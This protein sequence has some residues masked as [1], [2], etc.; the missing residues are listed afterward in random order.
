[1]SYRRVEP[2]WDPVVRYTIVPYWLKGGL[3][4]ILIHMALS[5]CDLSA[6]RVIWT[7]FG[8]IWV[9]FITKYS[10][11]GPGTATHPVPGSAP[12]PVPGSD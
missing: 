6:F 3:E 8:S 7:R 12:G 9:I 1:M 10:G 5:S 2:I 4:M 11:L